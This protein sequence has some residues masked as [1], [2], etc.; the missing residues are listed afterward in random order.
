MIYKNI[1]FFTILCHRNI[2]LFLHMIRT[3]LCFEV[4]KGV[5]SMTFY[6]YPISLLK[7]FANRGVCKKIIL[8][9]TKLRSSSFCT[10]TFCT[11]IHSSVYLYYSIEENKPLR[12]RVCRRG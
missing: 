7:V 9:I 8:S 5:A 4:L 10:S 6:I 1:F 11:S 2:I 12:R 3:H